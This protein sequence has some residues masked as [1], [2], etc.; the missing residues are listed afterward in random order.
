[1]GQAQFLRARSQSPG[2]C[3]HRNKMFRASRAVYV[4]YVPIDRN[5]SWV[6]EGTGCN[7]GRTQREASRG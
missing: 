7:H 5:K 1:V 3:V 2:Q 6:Y 4:L